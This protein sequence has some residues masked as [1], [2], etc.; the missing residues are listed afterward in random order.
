MLNQTFLEHLL[1]CFLSC[2]LAL[3]SNGLPFY[4]IG[5]KK[6]PRTDAWLIFFTSHSPLIQDMMMFY[7]FLLKSFRDA[8]QKVTLTG[9]ASLYETKLLQADLCLSG[10]LFMNRVTNLGV[11]QMTCQ[12]ILY[13]VICMQKH[14]GICQFLLLLHVHFGRKLLSSNV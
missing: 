7:N 9:I 11:H 5:N 14:S 2:N 10:M 12:Y 4:F 13:N 3:L 1:A 8:Q 6:K